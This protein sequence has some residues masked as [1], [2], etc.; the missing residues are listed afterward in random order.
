MLKSEIKLGQRVKDMVTGLKGIATAHIEYLNG[1][2]QLAVRP[3][4]LKDGETLPSEY[5]DIEQLDIIDA[6]LNKPK[7][8]YKATGTA[9]VKSDT[10]KKGYGLS[11]L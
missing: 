5:I 9:G 8:K 10:P 1:C 6:G 2:H 3:E 7:R 4:K 11:K